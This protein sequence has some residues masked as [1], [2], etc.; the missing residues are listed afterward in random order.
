LKISFLGWLAFLAVDFL[1][2]GAL[3]A[4]WYERGSPSLLSLE[5]AF[6]RIPLGYAAFFL[7]VML[8]VWLTARLGL[9][10]AAQGFGFGALL[11][12]LLAGS[13][14]L[15]LVSITAIDP[16]LI[17]WWSVA[18]A[19]EITVVGGIVGSALASDNL[20]RLSLVVV[21]G[22]ALSLALTITIQNL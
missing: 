21:I 18:E 7:L 3:L 11:G 20:R 17:L 14:G 15:A 22:V 16:A 10:G 9:R 1:V 12:S 5:E 4:E 2:H 19:G 13:R 6:A 8:I